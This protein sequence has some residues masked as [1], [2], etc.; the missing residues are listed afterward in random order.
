MNLGTSNWYNLNRNYYDTSGS[1]KS[2]VTSTLN[3]KPSVTSN[4]KKKNTNIQPTSLTD[5]DI[6]SIVENEFSPTGGHNLIVDPSTVY[7]VLTSPEVT[8]SSGFCTRYC[9]WHTYA[10]ASGI[11][12]K[13]GF[14]GH[15]DR[16]L[17]A[18]SEQTK[19]PNT[20]TGTGPSVGADAM[21]SIIAHE[22][23]E[24]ITDPDLNA[25]YDS[26][27][28]ENADKCVWTF[29]TTSHASNGALYNLNING[30]QF[31]VQQNWFYQSPTSQFC[32]LSA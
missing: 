17:S 25:W 28:N 5:N 26:A 30:K 23:A 2:F 8:A 11:N 18:C 4:W 7:L 3:L 22:T 16:C 1:T 14:I 24:A 32:A 6:L 20:V 12:I 29:G 19:G 10:T 13:Y 21:I 31:L 27:G 15:P 9:G